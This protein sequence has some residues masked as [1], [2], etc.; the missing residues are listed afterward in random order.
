[1]WCGSSIK[2]TLTLLMGA[3]FLISCQND[4]NN[5]LHPLQLI[6]NASDE[7]A[8][9]EVMENIDRHEVQI[10]FTRIHRNKN[11]IQFIDVDDLNSAEHFPDGVHYNAS[12]HQ[13]ISDR[14]KKII[15]DTADE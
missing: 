10:L 15:L 3:A 6:L 2:T 14:I 9:R 12:G 11:K 8:V 13:I 5:N 1:M 4:Q 7:N